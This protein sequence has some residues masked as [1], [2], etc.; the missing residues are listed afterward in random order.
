M[1]EETA[2]QA[3]RFLL[4]HAAPAPAPV[5]VTFFGGEPLLEPRL[6]EFIH[7]RLF[8]PFD[9]TKGSESM[10]I[11]AYQAR[12]YVRTLG[13]QMEVASEVGVGTTFHVRLTTND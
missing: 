2:E 13:G 8:R 11:G 12:D 9:S 3:I 10:G 5:S 6:I 1:T 7:E 4:D